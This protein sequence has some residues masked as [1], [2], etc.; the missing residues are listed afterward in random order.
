MNYPHPY[1]KAAELDQRIQIPRPCYDSA[2][3]P[4]LDY[5]SLPEEFSLDLMRGVAAGVQE[6]PHGS[7]TF[8]AETVLK[9]Q[10]HLTHA[11]H[12]VAGPDN[13]D[14]ILSVFTPKEPAKVPRP[15]LYH[16]HGGGMVSGDR[17]S[18]LTQVI[19]LLSGI[20]CVVVS[21][22]HRLAP[23]TR[24]PGPAEDCYAGLVWVSENAENLGIDPA[25]IVVFG[26]SGGGALAA[27]T[28]LM[29]RDRKSPAVPIKAQMLY[30]PLLDDRCE[31]VADKQFEYGNPAPTTWLRAIWDH[32]LVDERGSE[33]VTPY[34]APAR[35]T[36]LSNLP[37]A[38]I[39]A[40]ECE[41]F[42]DVAVAYASNMWRCGST[43]ELHIWP[44]AFH[45]F[46]MMDDP[47]I[48]LI[49][50]ANKAKANW[51]KRV[52]TTETKP[53]PAPMAHA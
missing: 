31:S 47:Q 13:N 30:S 1:S 49:N 17:F 21:V 27:A 12:V 23:E 15:A 33:N 35:E 20:D 26:V 28:C 42:R 37:P 9:D 7:H 14:V 32:I 25:A 16:I 2:L 52:L 39:D 38:Y 8:N 3:A 40:G 53:L 36:N 10:P 48:P 24:A 51:F 18:A 44:G 34:Q 22:E 45:G 4:M 19:D 50:I 11:E 6:C 41:V 43:C 5:A 46:D 29:A